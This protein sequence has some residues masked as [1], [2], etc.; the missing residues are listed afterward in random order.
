[1]E[2][3]VQAETKKVIENYYRSPFDFSVEL[4]SMIPG[5]SFTPQVVYQWLNGG[6]PRYTTLLAILYASEATG[7]IRVAEWATR[8]LAAAQPEYWGERV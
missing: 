7:N 3:S 8:L 2:M 5:L 1:M 6:V 4:S